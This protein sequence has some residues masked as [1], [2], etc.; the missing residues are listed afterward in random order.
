MSFKYFIGG[1]VSLFGVN[2]GAVHSAPLNW[3]LCHSG[4]F[5]RS[6]EQGMT[7]PVFI[8]YQETDEKASKNC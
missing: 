2:T 7:V 3:S 8:R 1:S 5:A 4:T 6:L